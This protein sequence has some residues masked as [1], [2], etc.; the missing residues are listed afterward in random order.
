LYPGGAPGGGAG[1]AARRRAGSERCRTG[2]QRPGQRG[3]AR[4]HELAAMD[5]GDGALRY[6]SYACSISAAKD[7]SLTWTVEVLVAP[8]LL[9]S[10]I[11]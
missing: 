5:H 11:C 1:G 8:I 3:T 2:R 6:A 10:S 9:F 4:L 7:A